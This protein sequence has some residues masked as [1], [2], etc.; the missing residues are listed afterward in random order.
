MRDES[1][2]PPPAAGAFAGASAARLW[3]AGAGAE[4]QH[5]VSEWVET[6]RKRAHARG[7]SEKTYD[8]R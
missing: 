2:P 1:E 4:V 5:F 7:I 8:Q 6:F 3:R